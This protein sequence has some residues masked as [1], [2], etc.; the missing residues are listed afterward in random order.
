MATSLYAAILAG[1]MLYLAAQVIKQRRKHQISLLDGD[2]EDL[3]VARSAHHNATE[4][5]PIALILLYLAESSGLPCLMVHLCGIALVTGRVL[6][7][8]AILNKRMKGRFY[9]MILTLITISVLA[10]SNIALYVM[11]L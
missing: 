3:K 10:L 1:W 9:G 2:V 8:I 6:H 4:Y 11:N 5:I 7:A